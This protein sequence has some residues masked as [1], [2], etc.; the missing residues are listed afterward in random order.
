MDEGPAVPT[1]R[2]LAVNLGGDRILFANGRS[3]FSEYGK[4]TLD[5]ALAQFDRYAEWVA[6]GNGMKNDDASP[7]MRALI[8]E[9]YRL[10]EKM[11]AERGAFND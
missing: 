5:Q 6:A 3:G 4:V 9:G 10:A 2:N 1:F 8:V 11:L 7:E